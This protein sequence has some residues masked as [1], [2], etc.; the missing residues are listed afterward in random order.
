M[1]SVVISLFSLLVM[2]WWL[3]AANGKNFIHFQIISVFLYDKR[4]L[5][6]ALA[7]RTHRDDNETLE[8]RYNFAIGFDENGKFRN[9]K[10]F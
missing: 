6:F 4:S 8:K 3:G 2:C 9:R 10:K 7:R 1:V 5:F